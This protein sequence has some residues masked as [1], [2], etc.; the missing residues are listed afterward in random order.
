MD[1]L[2]ELFTTHRSGVYNGFVAKYCLG[3]CKKESF[4]IK[5]YGWL[6]NC[7]QQW[8]RKGGSWRGRQQEAHIEP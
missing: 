8:L 6:A 3:N 2:L 4:L 1:A 7:S 5:N